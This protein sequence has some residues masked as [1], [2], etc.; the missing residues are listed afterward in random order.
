MHSYEQYATSHIKILTK[1]CVLELDGLCYLIFN[2]Y[3][4]HWFL[5]EGQVME[6]IVI[7]L[8]NKVN[9]TI[10]SK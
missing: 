3:I 1:S 7:N 4:N 6:P 5:L 8:K 2:K 9:Y 10:L